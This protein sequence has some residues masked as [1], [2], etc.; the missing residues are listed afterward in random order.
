[1]D[2]MRDQQR[3]RVY[4]TEDKHSFEG[5]LRIEDMKDVRRFS[6]KVLRHKALKP[7]R[8]AMASSKL[9]MTDGRG[10]RRAT[11]YGCFQTSPVVTIKLPR[12][13]RTQLN[14]IHELAHALTP[15]R[16]SPHGAEFTTNYLYLIKHVL[17]D[18]AY[19]EMLNLFNENRVKFDY[20]Y[21]EV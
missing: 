9:K 14:I 2:N 11:C 17:G 15:G 12:W 4:K 8:H 13:S 3:Q 6:K 1:M 5:I 10:N 7:W 18:G 21:Y 19:K 20:T 16:Y